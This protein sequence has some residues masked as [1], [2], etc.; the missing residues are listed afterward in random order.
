M[1]CADRIHSSLF[2]K[3]CGYMQ[4]EL[5]LCRQQGYHLPGYPVT[6]KITRLPGYQ[7]NNV[8]RLRFFSTHVRDISCC[9]ATTLHIQVMAILAGLCVNSI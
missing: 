5:L 6:N 2:T 3:K 8:T 7:G 4:L 1:F 9:I